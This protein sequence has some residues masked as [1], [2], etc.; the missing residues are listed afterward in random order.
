MTTYFVV[1]LAAVTRLELGIP[2]LPVGHPAAE[3]GR[4]ALAMIAASGVPPQFKAPGALGPALALH[5]PDF[6]GI[7]LGV[8][9]IARQ[10]GG[11]ELGFGCIDRQASGIKPQVWPHR[12]PSGPHRAPVWT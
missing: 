9:R 8:D 1:F 10:V 3:A 11:V 5:E 6:G 2:R 7:E 4:R 12:S